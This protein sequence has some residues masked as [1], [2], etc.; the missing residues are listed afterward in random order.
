MSRTKDGAVLEV[1][2]PN[3][4]GE[5]CVYVD[6]C[7]AG[8]VVDDWGKW[9]MFISPHT[10]DTTTVAMTDLKRSVAEAA[11]AAVAGQTLV[12]LAES[13]AFARGLGV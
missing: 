7:Y 8:L 9:G 11:E 1:H 4:Y 5:S 12:D 3:Q 6:G 2:P 10:P 13:T